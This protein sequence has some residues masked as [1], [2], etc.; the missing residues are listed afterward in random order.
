MQIKRLVINSHV[1]MICVILD[2]QQ[3]IGFAVRNNMDPWDSKMGIRVAINRAVKY[4]LRGKWF[5]RKMLRFKD[6]GELVNLPIKKKEMALC[7][8]EGIRHDLFNEGM[9]IERDD[10]REIQKITSFSK[11][12]LKIVLGKDEWEKEVTDSEV[13]KMTEMLKCSK[14]KLNMTAKE[15]A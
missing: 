8:F 13:Q 14:L 9:F 5:V 2:N 4:N 15:K 10:W 6:I 3:G 1:E 11:Y 7:F 12:N